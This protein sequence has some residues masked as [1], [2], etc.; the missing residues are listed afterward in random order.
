[1][2]FSVGFKCFCKKLKGDFREVS[3]VFQGSFRY[4][5]RKFLGQFKEVPRVFLAA[6]SSSRSDDVTECVCVLVS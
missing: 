3:K 5:Q 1:M 6:M 2:E 4:V